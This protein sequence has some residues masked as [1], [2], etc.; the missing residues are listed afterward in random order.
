[1]AKQFQL[2]VPKIDYL[3]YSS[4]YIAPNVFEAMKRAE[5]SENRDRFY[6]YIY[7]C[8]EA[9]MRTGR[10]NKNLRA[11]MVRVK[12]DYLAYVIEQGLPESSTFTRVDICIDLKT[13]EEAFG[14][15]RGVAYSAY[16][17]S[18]GQKGGGET[19]YFGE[20]TAQIFERIYYKPEEGGWR[21]EVEI[22]PKSKSLPFAKFA[23]LDERI[24]VKYGRL[25]KSQNIANELCYKPLDIMQKCLQPQEQERI[26]IIY[27]LPYLRR[28]G[29]EDFWLDSSQ[30]ERDYLMML[31]KADDDKDRRE[32][33]NFIERLSMHFVG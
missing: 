15:V 33:W 14:L 11:C 4:D 13:K 25:M 9:T 24:R 26:R 6:K 3:E 5:V 29:R 16:I 7:D 10:K 8:E 21:Y 23:A 17:D 18:R 32:D 28:A 31:Y 2:N 19:Y 30:I 20:R 22:K 27:G 1:M 12:H